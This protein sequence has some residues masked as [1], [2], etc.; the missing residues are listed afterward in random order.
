MIDVVRPVVKKEKEY[1]EVPF[2]MG[3]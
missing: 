2:Y 3:I 1:S